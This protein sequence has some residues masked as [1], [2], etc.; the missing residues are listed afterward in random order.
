M[1]TSLSTT[2]TRV[3]LSGWRSSS[4]PY[5]SAPRSS[6]A[7]P[8]R[9]GAVRANRNHGCG[10]ISPGCQVLSNQGS[11]GLYRRKR[12]FQPVPGMVWIQFD[13]LPAGALGPK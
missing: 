1:A 10:S 11:S 4:R 13:S 12:V 9:A 7:A 6:P 2:E 3:S 8:A 5:S